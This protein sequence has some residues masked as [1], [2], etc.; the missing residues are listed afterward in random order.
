MD[1]SKSVRSGF[2]FHH[3]HLLAKG[4]GCKLL[5]PSAHCYLPLKMEIIS[6][7]QRCV[8]MLKWKHALKAFSIVYGT[9]ETI[10][11]RATLNH[12]PGEAG[13]RTSMCGSIMCWSETY[14]L[15]GSAPGLQRSWRG[16]GCY[17]ET[18]CSPCKD[19]CRDVEGWRGTQKLQRGS[20]AG[21]S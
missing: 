21:R 10:N 2:G 13:E 9:W 16:T 20:G 3:W 14:H 15:W 11:I 12:I 17:A 19:W 1:N 8:L 6:H 4:L 5:G 7:P 18:G